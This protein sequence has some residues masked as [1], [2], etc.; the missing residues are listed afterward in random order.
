MIRSRQEVVHTFSIEVNQLIHDSFT[1]AY[2]RI[3]YLKQA[4][5]FVATPYENKLLAASAGFFILPAYESFDLR[6]EDVKY[7]SEFMA[8][9][10]RV[11][12]DESIDLDIKRPVL[13]FHQVMQI[14]LPQELCLE[15]AG[16]GR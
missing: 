12:R 9:C 15:F 7:L 3:C 2:G 10:E 13:R 14:A 4:G 8:M 5:L 6:R 16:V 1:Q 11:L